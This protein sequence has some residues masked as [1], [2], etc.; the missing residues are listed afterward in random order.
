MTGVPG[1][2]SP[3][4]WRHGSRWGSSLNVRIAFR[5]L[6]GLLA[7]SSRASDAQVL[8]TLPAHVDGRRIHMIA[9]GTG[10]PTI[11]LE[12]GFGSTSRTWGG[13]QLALASSYRVIA[14]DRAGLGAS[15]PSPRPR[16]ARIIAQELREALR[17]VGASPPFLLIGHSAGGLH[18]RVFASMFPRE[19]MG[20]VLVDPTPD[21]FEARARREL[22]GVFA[23]FDSIEN[24]GTASASAGERGED[25]GWAES[26]NDARRSNGGYPGRVIVLSASRPELFGLGAIWTD[27]HRRWS[28]AASNREYVLL[29]GAGHNIHRERPEVVIAAVRR[30]LATQ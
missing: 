24:A 11:V 3:S 17:S 26:L 18:V 12:A 28:A 23:H 9:A 5:C 15:D 25:A 7:L 1:S 30:I 22:P 19:T 14:Y 16:T 6:S 27:Q 10:G 20:L 13:L 4:Y 2:L 8:E 21:G 29:S